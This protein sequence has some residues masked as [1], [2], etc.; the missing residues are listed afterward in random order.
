MSLHT[1]ICTRNFVYCVVGVVCLLCVVCVLSVLCV[2]ALQLCI[3]CVCVVC[4]VMSWCESI[5][6][7]LYIIM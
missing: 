1:L 7:I 6:I 4:G 5:Y 2:F 3:A